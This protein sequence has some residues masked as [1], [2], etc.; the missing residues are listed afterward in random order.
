MPGT[1][2]RFGLDGLLGLL[3]G[4][5]DL[6]TALTGSVLIAMAHRMGVPVAVLLRM[7]ANLLIDLAIGSIPLV[8][9]AFDFGFKAHRRNVVLARR[10]LEASET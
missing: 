1:S 10:Y 4:I 6:A 9:D 7:A 8:G 3:P 2:L 5:G